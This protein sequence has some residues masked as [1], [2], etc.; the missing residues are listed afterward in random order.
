[1]YGIISF[2]FKI[3]FAS[4]IGGAFSYFPGAK[5]KNQ[6][7]IETSLICTLSASVLGLT[8]QFAEMGEY[9]AMGF[10]ILSVML[11]VVS[12]TKNLDF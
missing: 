11:M 8:R 2:G 9:I 3:L 5:V 12:I 1:M 4:I 10:G 7:V 6:G